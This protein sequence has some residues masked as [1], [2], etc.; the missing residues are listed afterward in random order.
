MCNFILRDS[1]LELLINLASGMTIKECANLMQ[2]GYIIT[3]IDIQN[4][5]KKTLLS[6]KNKVFLLYSILNIFSIC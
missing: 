3:G 4:S 5:A 6:I 2:K 1:Q